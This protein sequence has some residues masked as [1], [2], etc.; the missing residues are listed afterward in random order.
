MSKTYAIA[1]LI[2]G[3]VI[4]GLSLWVRELKVDVG[5]R[6]ATIAQQVK[7]LEQKDKDNKLL[8]EANATLKGQVADERQASADRA[9]KIK[10]LEYK[11]KD[12]KG[13]YD[14]ATKNDTCA[15][16]RA[17]DDVISLMQ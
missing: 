12:K 4:I 15:N 7:D 17:P 1:A 3:A 13:K 9:A 6:D 14:D 10:E 11:L 2:L 8:S 5:N 16:T